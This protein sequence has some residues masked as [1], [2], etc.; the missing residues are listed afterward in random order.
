MCRG[1]IAPKDE[2]ER[3]EAL[4]RVRVRV[5]K[6]GALFALEQHD[7]HLCTAKNDAT[8]IP[9]VRRANA[10]HHAREKLLEHAAAVAHVV[11]AVVARKCEY[12]LA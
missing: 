11:V 6:S 3:A 8:Y 5:L 12:I 10:R 1:H 4:S 7:A 2:A 9:G